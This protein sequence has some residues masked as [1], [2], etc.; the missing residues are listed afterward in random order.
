MLKCQVWISSNIYKTEYVCT[1]ATNLSSKRRRWKIFKKFEKIKSTFIYFYSH[2]LLPDCESKW[3]YLEQMNSVNDLL[4]GSKNSCVPVTSNYI[5]MIYC[6]DC[7]EH[8]K[9]EIHLSHNTQM[10]LM[11][12]QE[13]GTEWCWLY[14]PINF[15]CFSSSNLRVNWNRPLF[16][17]HLFSLTSAKQ[18]YET[19]PKSINQPGKEQ[20]KLNQIEWVLSF[21]KSSISLSSFFQ[22]LFID[23]GW[24]ARYVLELAINFLP[25][26]LLQKKKQNP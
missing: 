4:R 21:P 1:S 19:P 16:C 6:R 23:S 15:I 26:F 10:L 3:N 8:F 7:L 17:C 24:C 13:W 12:Q 5:Q 18:I 22:L 2:L 9:E 11:G 25:F 14:L 20:N